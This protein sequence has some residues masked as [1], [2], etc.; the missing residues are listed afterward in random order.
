MA[1]LSITHRTALLRLVFQPTDP[2]TGRT[3]GSYQRSMAVATYWIR[4][5][6]GS[7][8]YTSREAR[9]LMW[10]LAQVGFVEPAL[11]TCAGAVTHWRITDAGIA[12]LGLEVRS[13]G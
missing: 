1:E 11:R 7:A 2:R 12:A 9:D 4:Q 8:A 3:N 10:R 13:H 5:A 6:I